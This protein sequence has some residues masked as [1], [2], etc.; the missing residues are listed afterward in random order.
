MEIE[1]EVGNIE[2]GTHPFAGGREQ[3]PF[4]WLQE[5]GDFIFEDVATDYFKDLVWML[6]RGCDPRSASLGCHGLHLLH[7]G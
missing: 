4:V 7:E 2:Y 3:E 1:I 5:F 6:R